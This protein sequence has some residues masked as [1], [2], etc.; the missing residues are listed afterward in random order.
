M[1]SLISLN[2][3]LMVCHNKKTIE[4]FMMVMQRRW[5]TLIC[6]AYKMLMQVRPT[7]YLS[8]WIV[9]AER[10]LINTTEFWMNVES[11]NY[12]LQHI[13]INSNSSCFHLPVKHKSMVSIKCVCARVLLCEDCFIVTKFQQSSYGKNA[14]DE[15][16]DNRLT[17]KHGGDKPRLGAAQPFTN[18]VQP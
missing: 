6:G 13:H 9:T 14:C 1:L 18:I 7:K 16:T 4:G 11:K 10:K 15:S 17:C 2:Q 12:L 5:I 3:L 8:P